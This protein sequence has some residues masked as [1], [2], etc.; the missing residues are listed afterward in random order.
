MS[1]LNVVYLF[2]LGISASN[3]YSQNKHIFVSFR[4]ELTSPL[5]GKILISSCLISS[6]K[7]FSLSK[8]KPLTMTL[9]ATESI[10][11]C[12]SRLL[13]RCIVIVSFN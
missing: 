8:I 7:R 1:V 2:S 12:L 9:V 3:Q 6:N 13:D 10:E 5:S 4:H 11:F